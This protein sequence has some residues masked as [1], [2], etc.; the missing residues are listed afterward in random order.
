[1]L[2]M[3]PSGEF[4]YTSAKNKLMKLDFTFRR[5]SRTTLVTPGDVFLGGSAFGDEHDAFDAA[6]QH[7][8][9]TQLA[10]LI[11]LESHLTVSGFIA[12][13]TSYSQL[14][15]CNRLAVPVRY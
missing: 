7:E 14:T 9:F 5:G 2:D 3:R 8:R 6:G 11:D 10:G 1:M 13:P 15:D 12:L 4:E